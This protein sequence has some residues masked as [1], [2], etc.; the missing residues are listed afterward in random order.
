ME[1]HLVFRENKLKEKKKSRRWGAVIKWSCTYNPSQLSEE[2]DSYWYTG[3]Q[4]L[5]VFDYSPQEICNMQDDRGCWFALND[6]TY[7][8]VL[9][10][11]PGYSCPLR[12]FH[13]TASLLLPYTGYTSG[14]EHHPPF[15][16]IFYLTILPRHWL[17]SWW[18][19]FGRFS[20]LGKAT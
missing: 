17:S 18:T 14:K 20:N 3:T 9:F 1:T 11:L 15:T 5:S 6:V 16:W 7:H 4:R 2:K 12:S 13:T 10:S 19:A 8:V